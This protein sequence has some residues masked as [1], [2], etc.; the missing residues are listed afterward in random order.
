MD[1]WL[2]K[3]VLLRTPIIPLPLRK[4]NIFFILFLLLLLLLLLLFL[5]KSKAPIIFM[6]R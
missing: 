1:A 2:Y 6:L 3:I 4:L 5:M